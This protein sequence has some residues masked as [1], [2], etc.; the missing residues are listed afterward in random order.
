MPLVGQDLGEFSGVCQKTYRFLTR[1]TAGQAN[2]IGETCVSEL[3]L[4]GSPEQAWLTES[5]WELK[6]P[7]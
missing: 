2:P 5:G 3:T 4:T 7:Q 1:K 6:Q